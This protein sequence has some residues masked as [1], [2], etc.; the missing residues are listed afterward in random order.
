MITVDEDLIILVVVNEKNFLDKSI[1]LLKKLINQDNFLCFYITFNKPAKLLQKLFKSKKIDL[2]RVMFID[3]I[4]RLSEDVDFE[5]NLVYID[6]P[7][8]LTNLL[9]ILRNHLDIN[10]DIKRRVVFIDS[11]SNIA[12]YNSEKETINFLHIL[13]NKLK[14]MEV[15]SRIFVIKGG[16]VKEMMLKEC[17]KYADKVI[18]LP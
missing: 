5:K 13:T 10:S 14:L 4:T 8:H 2:N 12:N 15:H 11:L 16:F 17:G 7:E 1:S 6:S 9:I 18:E 3:A